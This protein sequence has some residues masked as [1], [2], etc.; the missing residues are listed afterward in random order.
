M[1]LIVGR[2]RVG[3]HVIA[4]WQATQPHRALQ[5]SE[6]VIASECNERRNRKIGEI[7]RLCDYDVAIA[8]RN[9]KTFLRHCKEGKP[10]AEAEPCP[11]NARRSPTRQSTNNPLKLVRIILFK[12]PIVIV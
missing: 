8:P 4:R 9:D 2:V 1:T 3:G 5:S 10:R 6:D 12:F 11:F 7:Q